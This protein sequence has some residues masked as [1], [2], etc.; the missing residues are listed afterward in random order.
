MDVSVRYENSTLVSVAG[1]VMKNDQWN[2][3]FII[4]ISSLDAEN[5]PIWVGRWN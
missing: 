3:L 5:G 4:C 2:Y 1:G